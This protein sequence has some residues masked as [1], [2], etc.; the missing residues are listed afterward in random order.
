MGLS[1]SC[2]RFAWFRGSAQDRRK[3]LRFS[4]PLTVVKLDGHEHPVLIPAY[5]HKL[6]EIG[7]RATTGPR[8]LSLFVRQMALKDATETV[9]PKDLRPCVMVN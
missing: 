6:F 2:S 5:G 8:A 1:G 3:W 4:P 9:A 7:W